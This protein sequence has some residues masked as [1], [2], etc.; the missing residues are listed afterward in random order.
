MRSAATGA[1]VR[2][3][4]AST[5]LSRARRPRRARRTHGTSALGVLLDGALD[6]VHGLLHA[7]VDV[8]PLGALGVQPDGQGRR[9]LVRP[10]VDVELPVVVVRAGRAPLQR[11]PLLPDLDPRLTLDVLLGAVRR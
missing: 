6:A 7:T 1:S 9:P 2:V 5:S 3:A 11:A 10:R 8:V 4:E